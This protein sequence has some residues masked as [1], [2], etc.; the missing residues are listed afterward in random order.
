[1]FLFSFL[2]LCYYSNCLDVVFFSSSVLARRTST[3]WFLYHGAKVR[4]V[5][6]SHDA[7]EKTYLPD[8]KTQLTE[9]DF[10]QGPWW[11]E[12]TYDAAWAVEF[13]EHVGVN[14]HFNYI[15]TFRKAAILFVTSSRWGGWHHVEVHDDPWWIRKYES[16]G[17]Q[18][19]DELTKQ[20]RGWARQDAHIGP[21]G[22]K[23]R[24]QHIWLS[25]KVFINPVVASL[26]Q[27]AHLFPELGCFVKREE[28]KLVQREC[29][30][31]K[32]E[33]KTT[34]TK[35]PDSYTPLKLT[36]EMDEKW[37]EMIRSKLDM[38]KLAELLV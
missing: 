32:E 9:H 4:C 5:E 22:K 31:G 13:L 16:Y 6:G 25:M 26:P 33:H 23:V 27:H 15:S 3:S 35:L 30:V 24:A 20:V 12:D 2:I 29:G 1:M 11:P 19:S 34:E 36:E 28:G 14:Y 7:V 8:P 21:H 18:Y 37:N 17:F 10:S 38:K